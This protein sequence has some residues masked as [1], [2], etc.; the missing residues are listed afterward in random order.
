MRTP[1]RRQAL[2]SRPCDQ[3]RQKPAVEG[4]ARAGGVDDLDLRRGHAQHRAIHQSR[5]RHALPAS[6]PCDAPSSASAPTACVRVRRRVYRRASRSLTNTQS[7][8][9]TERWEP[10]R[11]GRSSCQPKSHDVVMPRAR[12]RSSTRSHDDKSCG[13]RARCTWRRAAAAGG[14]RTRAREPRALVHALEGDEGAVA[15]GGER[16]R[17][18]VRLAAR[19]RLVNAAPLGLQA[20]RPSSAS[21]LTT[22]DARPAPA[23]AT[24]VIRVPPPIVRMNA[25]RAQFLAGPRQAWQAVED[26][27]LE[28]FADADR[29]RPAAA[30]PCESLL[31]RDRI[32]HRLERPWGRSPSCNRRS[33]SCC[34][35]FAAFKR[36]TSMPGEPAVSS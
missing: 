15:P 1:S 12:S 21:A 24:A 31:H 7:S 13:P 20:R 22:V 32:A 2:T 18:R 16:H 23:A 9:P 5:R 11:P 4:V 34:R 19:R 6:P 30:V 3:R 8:A 26:E 10:R 36:N 17:H 28:R 33:T 27:V 25:P 29:D 35:A 14:E